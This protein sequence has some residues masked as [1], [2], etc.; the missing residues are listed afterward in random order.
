M[1]ISFAAAVS[2]TVLFTSCGR[3]ASGNVAATINGRSITYAEL[4]KQY[5]V[6]QFGSS[7]ERPSDDQVMIQRLEILRAMIDNEIM[8]QRAEREGLLAVD[9]DVEARFSEM[10]TPYT[11]EEFQKQL[12]DRKMT[13][14]DLKAQLRRDLSA[15]KLL[16]KETTA[17]ISIADK[18]I[19]DFYESNKASFNRAEPQLH[20]AQI[21]V[22]P[23]NDPVVRNLKG[24]NALDEAQ[25][26]RKITDLESRLKKGEDFGELA[27]NYSEDA[28]S[29]AAGGDLGFIPQSA[30]E[31]SD[32][33]LRRTI[34]ELRPGQITPVLK[35]AE[36]YRILKLMTREP[37][38]QRALNDPNV[39]QTIRS[40]LITRK[41][42]LLRDAF[43][44]VARNEAEVVNYYAKTVISGTAAPAAPTTP[45]A[46][47]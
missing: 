3:T 33:G 10:R 35:T 14:E 20:L 39:Q 23:A 16:N 32:T 22:T 40:T 11:E 28:D 19:T 8:L 21:L 15:Q 43:Y 42:Q 46:K 30:F 41:E 38:G 9:S 12:N 36:G 34:L 44:E 7:G 18:D 5:Q 17:K 31:T 6:A 26:R 27:Q 29:A 47:Q 1:R 37:A 25:A 24:D 2:I 13:V 4:D 45:A